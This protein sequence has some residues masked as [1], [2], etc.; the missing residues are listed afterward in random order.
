MS[1]PAV[2]FRVRRLRPVDACFITLPLFIAAFD[3]KSFFAWLPDSLIL[4]LAAFLLAATCP[5]IRYD[6]GLYDLKQSI[7]YGY[8]Q[9]EFDV[10]LVQKLYPRA[11]LTPS[12]NGWNGLKGREIRSSSFGKALGDIDIDAHIN[13]KNYHYVEYYSLNKDASSNSLQSNQSG[14]KV[15]YVHCHP[16]HAMSAVIQLEVIIRRSCEEIPGFTNRVT[17]KVHVPTKVGQFGSFEGNNEMKYLWNAPVIEVRVTACKFHH[18]SRSHCLKAGKHLYTDMMA[19]CADLSML[20]KE[21]YKLRR[22]IKDD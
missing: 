2:V 16:E 3:T 6:W 22:I 4:L 20:Q 9:N 8:L 10:N 5:K 11:S 19:K 13:L 12:N 18:W 7:F 17:V 21:C 15:C 14:A 1:S